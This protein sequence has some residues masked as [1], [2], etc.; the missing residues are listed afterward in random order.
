M[1]TIESSRQD[2]LRY[3]GI[4]LLIDH[5]QQRP[6]QFKF[7]AEVSACERVQQ[8]AAIALTRICKDK[9]TAQVIAEQGGNSVFI[10]IDH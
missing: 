2:I 6:S 7:E 10:L 3:S 1:A 5:L 4:S 8:K 9:N